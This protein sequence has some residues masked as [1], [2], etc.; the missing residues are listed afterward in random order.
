MGRW[1]K[2]GRASTPQ[3][4]KKSEKPEAT[5]FR[6]KAVA[7]G[8]VDVTHSR[9]CADDSVD[10]YYS[11]IEPCVWARAHDLRKTPPRGSKQRRQWFGHPYESPS[12]IALDVYAPVRRLPI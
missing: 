2:R 10:T 11:L 3:K 9:P 4:V 5:A 6:L 8:F 12:R 1:E 7:L